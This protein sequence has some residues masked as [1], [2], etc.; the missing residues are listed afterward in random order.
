MIVN[1]LL[2]VTIPGS[3]LTAENHPLIKKLITVLKEKKIYGEFV[4][5]IAGW[6]D[7]TQSWF[8][9]E[10][11]VDTDWSW[12]HPT[13]FTDE[14]WWGNSDAPEG[15]DR[16]GWRSFFENGQLLMMVHYIN[17]EDENKT[18]TAHH[19]FALAQVKIL[20]KIGE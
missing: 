3:I 1:C 7:L 14:E 13:C 15:I 11:E 4:D 18:Y 2:D 20:K 12:V 19:Q 5:T 9:F 10:V 8:E 6:G 16:L 17:G